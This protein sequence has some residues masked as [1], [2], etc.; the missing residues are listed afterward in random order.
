MSIKQLWKGI[1]SYHCGL[2]KEYAYAFSRE[3]ARVIMA[4]RLAK[5]HGVHPSVV[6]GMFDGKRDNFSIEIEMEVKELERTFHLKENRQN[7]CM[8]ADEMIT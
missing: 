8:S 4:R 2:E 7:C 6:L 3:Q 1:F 5:K